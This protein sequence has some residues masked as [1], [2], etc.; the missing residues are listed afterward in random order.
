MQGPVV[1]PGDFDGLFIETR[2]EQQG[3]VGSFLKAHRD[4]VGGDIHGGGCV[5]EVAEERLRL[6]A[7]V[8]LPDLLAEETVE[9][10]GHEGELE[11]AVH[12]HGDGGG[13]RVHMEELDAVLDGVLDDHAA[14]IAFDEFG[15]GTFEL[16]G[17]QERGF[18][19]PQILD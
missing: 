1:E 13:Q 8:T 16:I 14:G 15:G 9:A 4:L 18:L 3:V 10:A 11:V 5:N 6:G 2:R 12:F 7:L 19:V 17:D